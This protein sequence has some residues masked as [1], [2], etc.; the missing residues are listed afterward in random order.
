MPYKFPPEIEK[1]LRE[2]DSDDVGQVADEIRLCKMLIRRAVEQGNSGLA[3]GLLSTIAK[4]SSVQ[5]A[6]QVRVGQL[7]EASAVVAIAQRLSAAIALRLANVPN[8]EELLD[9]LTEDFR[10]I[11]RTREQPLQLTHEPAGPSESISLP[12]GKLAP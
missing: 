11:F 6:N 12:L 5:I 4:L 9:A 10:E 3:N 1:E 2:F 7:L 8:R